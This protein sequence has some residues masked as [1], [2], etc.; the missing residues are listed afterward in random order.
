MVVVLPAAGAGV[1]P[2]A[3]PFAGAIFTVGM[4]AFL[5]GGSCG[6]GP[7]PAFT[8]RRADSQAFLR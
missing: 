2:P 1:L 5:G 8:G 3:H 7:M 4:S 6:L